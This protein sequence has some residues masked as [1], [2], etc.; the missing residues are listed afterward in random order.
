MTLLRQGMP[1]VWS[2][3]IDVAE[4]FACVSVPKVTDLAEE[5]AG[6]GAQQ[7]ESESGAGHRQM[8]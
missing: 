4:E 3:T 5:W 1:Q 8:V 6:S 7:E 2:R